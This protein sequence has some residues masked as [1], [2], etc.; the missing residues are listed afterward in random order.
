M[1]PLAWQNAYDVLHC[2]N[3]FNSLAE[4]LFLY[5]LSVTTTT[6]MVTMMT[7]GTLCEFTMRAKYYYGGVAVRLCCRGCRGCMYRAVSTA[8]TLAIQA[9]LFTGQRTG[10]IDKKWLCE[11]AT[12]QIVLVYQ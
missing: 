8:V 6:M 5:K 4:R 9:V 1:N 12:R 11:L 10:R 7:Y 2:N 3:N